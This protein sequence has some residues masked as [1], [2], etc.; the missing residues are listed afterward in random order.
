MAKERIHL[1][2]PASRYL[3][4]LLRGQPRITIRQLLNHTTGVFDFNEDPK[5]L[6]PYPD[7]LL[8]H[9]WSPRSLV[10]IAL[11]H[12][13]VARPGTEY[14][15][16]NTNYLL[17]GLVVEAVTGHPLGEVL[18]NRVFSPAH[19]STTTFT[20]SRKSARPCSPRVLHVLGRRADRHHVP[21]PLPVGFR[22]DGVDR[23]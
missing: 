2:D 19:L 15:Y 7:G 18:R 21:L 12:A 3:P 13:P 22:V 5:V 11:T 6:A 8:G 20:P 10:R 1:G 23:P 14:H 16:S 4:D 9:V 17:A